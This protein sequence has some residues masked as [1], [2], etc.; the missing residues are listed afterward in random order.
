M[1]KT[2][3]VSIAEEASRR[4][5]WFSLASPS[6]AEMR[7]LQRSAGKE[8]APKPRREAAARRRSSQLG[9]KSCDVFALW[10]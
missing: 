10:M 3:S 7:K 4:G 6:T 2:R 1:Q 8:E 5:H 9:C